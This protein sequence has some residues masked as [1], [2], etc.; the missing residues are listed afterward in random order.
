MKYSS[1][2]KRT[3]R[4]AVYLVSKTSRL[5]LVFLD[6]GS[7]LQHKMEYFSDN[8]SIFVKSNRIYG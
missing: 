6:Y 5:V 3:M 1:Y 2:I 8:Y 7:F 4:G